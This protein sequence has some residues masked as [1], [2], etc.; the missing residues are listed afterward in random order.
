MDLA[1]P[2]E[3]NLDK[4]LQALEN[5]PVDTLNL[6]THYKYIFRTSLREAADFQG[7]ADFLRGLPNGGNT[8]QKNVEF[9]FQISQSPTHTG[10]DKPVLK[11]AQYC[12]DAGL[13][14]VVGVIHGGSR[15]LNTFW[16]TLDALAALHPV[17]YRGPSVAEDFGMF[18][19]GKKATTTWSWADFVADLQGLLAHAAGLADGV[20]ILNETGNFFEFTV[21]NDPSAGT[22]D[23]N[24]E[25]LLTAPKGRI[26]ALQKTNHLEQPLTALAAAQGLWQ[27]GGVS[28][29]GINAK[30]SETF[31][32]TYG[33][34]NGLQPEDW[35]PR[36]EVAA[37]ANG[38]T[39]FLGL[40]GAEN[41]FTAGRHEHFIQRKW[42]S[43]EFGFTQDRRFKRIALELMLR[44]IVRPVSQGKILS[45]QA[46]VFRVQPNS[47]ALSLRGDQTGQGILLDGQVKDFWA[48][49]LG[50]L[51]ALIGLAP[52]NIASYL[53]ATDDPLP[54]L[55]G[56]WTARNSYGS[57]RLMPDY[58]FSGPSPWVEI[59]TDG[60]TML[61]GTPPEQAVGPVTQLFQTFANNPQNLPFSASLVHLIIQAWDPD[62]YQLFLIDP[63][64][65]EVDSPLDALVDLRLSNRTILTCQDAITL[66]F[67][68]V[69]GGKQVSAPVPAGAFRIL[70]VTLAP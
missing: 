7:I 16:P 8:S 45:A 23:P 53:V 22:T 56:T 17:A 62:T 34:F 21:P 42:D 43:H 5:H 28:A 67:L 38:A 9:L 6:S 15:R 44:G 3:T 70:N 30:T 59:D 4:I 66:D 55:A 46:P 14:F 37:L 29:F 52:G 31:Q 36:L 61:G 18:G 20:L 26:V 51:S 58:L 39:W 13:G 2:V 33:S 47:Y 32:W 48:Q 10:D 57:I 11:R 63:R 60:N 27:A 40:V 41:R 25:E 24:L 12:D 69:I 1:N 68:T 49:G 65:W 54:M 35:D 19:K 64:F 50:G